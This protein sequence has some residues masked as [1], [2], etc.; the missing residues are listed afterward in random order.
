[1]AA[2]QAKITGML[3]TLAVL[4]SACMSPPGPQSDEAAVDKLPRKS[5]QLPS[6][7]TLSYLETGKADGRLVVFVHGTPGNA[8]GWSDYLLQVPEG[9]HY[10]AIDRPGFGESGPDQAVVSLPEQAAAVAAVIREQKSGP[11]ILVGHSLGGP[12]VVQTAADAPE[13][14][15]ALVILAGSLDPGQESVPFVQYLGDTW[16]LSA[17]LPRPMR[18]ANREIIYL[19]GE[20]DRL[21]PRLGTIR[22]P[23]VIVHGMEDPLVPF[24]NVAFMKAHFIDV[25]MAVDAIPRQNHFLPWNAKAHVLAAI[26]K[27]AAEARP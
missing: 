2:R 7:Y 26:A 20:L 1:M 14:V 21:A 5:L 4:L 16:P 27:A 24:A 6:G 25:P 23:V 22:M 12:V 17:L 15:S 9:F 11:A 19:K 13:L 18:N 10:I 3:A 8:R